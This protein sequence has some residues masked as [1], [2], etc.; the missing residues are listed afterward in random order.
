MLTS[1]PGRCAAV[2][3][4]RQHH[5]RH[6][7][8]QHRSHGHSLNKPHHHRVV[9]SLTLT[10]TLTQLLLQPGGQRHSTRQENSH[11]VFHRQVRIKRLRPRTDDEVTEI[12]VIRRHVH[13]DHRFRARAAIEREL[14]RQEPDHRPALRIVDDHDF[15]ESRLAVGRERRDQ[16]LHRRVHR[17]EQRH[18]Q[19][20]LL[21]A[22]Q[23]PPANHVGRHRADHQDERRR[24][25]ARPARESP[26]RKNTP[27][28]AWPRR[29]SPGTS[30]PASR[31]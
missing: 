7:H 18:V 2:L 29:R 1:P 24:S 31:R 11:A 16:L 22:L 15:L 6:Q 28:A 27:T 5:R 19:Q 25:S 10:A 26:A 8:H 14:A 4:R 23:N 13:R 20:P 9:V 3:L 21:A 12:Q 17:L 30:R